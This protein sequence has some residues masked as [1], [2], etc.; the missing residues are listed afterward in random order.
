MCSTAR[1]TRVRSSAT[2]REA[3]AMDCGGIANV[4]AA[5]DDGTNLSAGD[6]SREAIAAMPLG[7][8]GLRKR[9]EPPGLE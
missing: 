6:G 4:Y 5:P 2:I 3:L 9:F 8:D 7:A 1:T